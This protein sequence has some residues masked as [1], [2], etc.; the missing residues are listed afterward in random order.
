MPTQAVSLRLA[1]TTWEWEA[2]YGHRITLH[3]EGTATASWRPG[4]KGYWHVNPD[5]TVA[6]W[7]TGHPG[8]AVM[9]F[10][11]DYTA[12]ESYTPG[13]NL[14]RSGKRLK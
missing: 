8:G 13:A 3:A 5:L 6:W 9:R 11:K 10:V 7:C 12:H 1:D 4:A 14:P 2:Q